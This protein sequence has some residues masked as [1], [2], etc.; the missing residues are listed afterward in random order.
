M[1][2]GGWGWLLSRVFPPD[3]QATCQPALCDSTSLPL[4]AFSFLALCL[5]STTALEVSSVTIIYPEVTPVV[6]HV[7]FSIRACPGGYQRSARRCDM[8]G[9]KPVRR[10]LAFSHLP[11]CASCVYSCSLVSYLDC[12]GEL[13]KK[14]KKKDVM[15]NVAFA[16]IYAPVQYHH[17]PLHNPAL[18]TGVE[19]GRE[20]AK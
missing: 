12:I 17:P 5:L 16:C 19:P 14:K 20:V 1:G 18:L 10:E 3:R 2:N 8:R 6:A 11:L 13:P 4:A 7:A 9:A 15:K